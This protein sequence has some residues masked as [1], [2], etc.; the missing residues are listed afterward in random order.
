MTQKTIV[1]FRRNNLDAFYAAFTYWRLF[2]KHSRRPSD[3]IDANVPTIS[4]RPLD[5][6]E[7][8]KPYIGLGNTVLSIGMNMDVPNAFTKF[9]SYENDATFTPAGP[10]EETC[11]YYYNQ[12][13]KLTELMLMSLE[14]AGHIDH[15]HVD[16]KKLNQFFNFYQGKG[17]GLEIN[18]KIAEQILSMF[19]HL[20]VADFPT[21]DKLIEDP[22]KFMQER[23]A[24]TPEAALRDYIHRR[25]AEAD[26]QSTLV[27]VPFDDRDL[28]VQMRMINT[29][30]VHQ[31][32]AEYV[33]NN[34]HAGNLLRVGE[35]TLLYQFVADGFAR[36]KYFSSALGENALNIFP[37]GGQRVGNQYQAEYVVNAR[38]LFTLMF[39]VIAN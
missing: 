30:L 1:L 13:K 20:E 21:L 29:D 6:F 17:H 27:Q 35:A 32:V 9:F 39:G 23:S 19:P 15:N 16:L 33:F 34:V 31:P 38:D 3:V 24:K 26:E 5:V 18:T 7:D 2:G 10:N 11:T 25:A 36:V 22:I 12:D 8:P 14:E 37:E 28:I 4:F